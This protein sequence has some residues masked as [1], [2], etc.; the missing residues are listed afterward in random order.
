MMYRYLALLGI[1]LTAG[2]ARA[3]DWPRFRG[4]DNN[5]ISK[6]KGLLQAWPAGDPKILWTAKLGYGFS[7]MAVSQG[8][9]YTMYQD[10]IEGDGAQYVTCLDEK[11]GKPLWPAPVKTGP[12]F[13]DSRDRFHGPRST[14]T[15]E[16]DRVYALDALGNAVCLNAADGKLVWARNILELTGGVNNKWGMA[17]SPFIYGDTVIFISGGSCSSLFIALN[18]NTGET[19]WKCAEGGIGAYDTPVLA[20]IGG[21]EQLVWV[22]GDLLVG[23]NPKDG[24]ILWRYPWNSTNDLNSV[25]PLV[26]DDKAFVSGG[27]W[28]AGEAARIDPGKANATR[29]WQNEDLTCYMQ[30]PILLGD[31]IYGFNMQVA[32]CVDVNGATKWRE[33]ELPAQSQLIYADGLFYIWHQS[34]TFT[35]ARLSPSGAQILGSMDV[36]P[37]NHNW[38][39][40]ALANGRLYLRSYDAQQVYC[41]DVKA[42]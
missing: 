21:V 40:P 39:I 6:E 11:T 36:A 9:I 20:R 42:K 23:L 28:H 1:V 30:L 37:G 24:K 27:Y 32:A 29:L 12:Y 33:N 5:G 18:K 41:I 2:V 26:W 35:L 3:E 15:V 7:S 14:P 16:K 25:S 34:G 22:T 38:S 8:R 17:Q 31:C 4:P 13:Y 19:V 10:K